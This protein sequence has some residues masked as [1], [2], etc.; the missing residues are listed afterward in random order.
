MSARNVSLTLN[1][2]PETPALVAAIE[3]DNPEASILRFPSMIKIDCPGRLVINRQTVADKLGRDW[4]VQEMQLQ[5]I[6]LS[7]N[8]DEDDDYFAV[9][10]R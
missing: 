1:V 5:M 10:W 3:A 7:G 4:E 8:L 9:A 2:T 6:S